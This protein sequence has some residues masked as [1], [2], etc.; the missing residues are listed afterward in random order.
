MSCRI[1]ITAT[2]TT[3]PWC[4]RYTPKARVARPR[5]QPPVA[6]E[7][8]ARPPE[9][10]DH[11][12]DAGE[13][14]SASRTR[15]SPSSR[16]R[17]RRRPRNQNGTIA[18]RRDEPDARHH[19]AVVVDESSTDAKPPDAEAA[20]EEQRVIREVRPVPHEVLLPGPRPP[21]QHLDRDHQRRRTGPACAGRRRGLRP[22]VEPSEALA[23]TAART[24]AGTRGTTVRPRDGDAAESI[25]D[26]LSPMVRSW[27]GGLDPSDED[28]LGEHEHRERDPEAPQPLGADLRRRAAAQ[29]GGHRPSGEHEEQRHVPLVHE[30]REHVEPCQARRCSSRGTTASSRTPSPCGTRA[31]GTSPPI[32]GCRCRAVV[33]VVVMRSPSDRTCDEFDGARPHGFVVEAARRRVAVAM[34]RHPRDRLDGEARRDR[35]RRAVLGSAPAWHGGRCTSPGSANSA[36]RTSS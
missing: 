23:G 26:P 24:P 17:P 30:A 36:S 5:V 32:A 34:A 33:A 29:R 31:A 10:P 9:D 20:D 27:R 3:Q 15:G 13:R 6:G 18:R 12:A 28:A 11:E 22:R 1:T 8:A 21:Q 35:R 14:A 25:G 16:S 2:A 4:S 19:D 7:V